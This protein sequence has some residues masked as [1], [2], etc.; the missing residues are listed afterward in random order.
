MSW[1]K[2]K[3]RQVGLAGMPR[4]NLIE[5][6]PLSSDSEGVTCVIYAPV[7]F[8]TFA[9]ISSELWERMKIPGNPGYPRTAGGGGCA[10]ESDFMF[11]FRDPEQLLGLVNRLSTDWR[12]AVRPYEMSE[13]LKL[14]RRMEIHRKIDKGEYDEQDIKG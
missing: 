2:G 5:V 4:S 12:I 13:V 11:M 10:Y 1:F 3:I 8:D 14:F 9:A 6:R 7:P